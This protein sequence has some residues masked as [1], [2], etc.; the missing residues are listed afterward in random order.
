MIL[1]KLYNINFLTLKIFKL[2][3]QLYFHVSIDTLKKY[4]TIVFLGLESFS[5]SKY[6]TAH[7]KPFIECFSRVNVY[8]KLVHSDHSYVL[9]KVP[10]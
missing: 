2:I 5:G 7:A 10:L 3:K 9:F 1:K 4:S 8:L 6:K